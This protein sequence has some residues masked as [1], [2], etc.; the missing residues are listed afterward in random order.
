MVK[1]N[2]K[3]DYQ[4][5]ELFHYQQKDFYSLKLC[6]KFIILFNFKFHLKDF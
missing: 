2:Q 1:R 3:E 6:L 5:F 4:K